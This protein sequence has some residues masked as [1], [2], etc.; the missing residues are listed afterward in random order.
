MILR[1]LKI[2]TGL[3]IVVML[4][5]YAAAGCFDHRKYTLAGVPTG[6]FAV[7]EDGRQFYVPRGGPPVDQRPQVTMTADQYQL[8]EENDEASSLWGSR[9]VLCFFA[10]VGLAIWAR[11]AGP[12]PRPGSDRGPVDD[13]SR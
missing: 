7:R 3:L 13:S 11:L 4:G 6:H 2:T 1:T 8:W 10:V 9:G 12:G 5:C